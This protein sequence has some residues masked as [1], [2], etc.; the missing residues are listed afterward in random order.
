M[1]KAIFLSSVLMLC[2]AF[3]LAQDT[4]SSSSSQAGSNSTAS[5]GSATAPDQDATS[6]GNTIQGCLSGTSGNY[7]L[8]DATGVMYQLTGD[9]AQLSAN[10]NKE[11]EVT[12]T[13]GAKAS[14]PSTNSP[15]AN[16]PGSANAGEASASGNAAGT[17]ANGSP[18]ANAAKTLEVTSIKKVA[19]SCSSG[20]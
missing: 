19:D 20:K 11:V 10:L 15:E 2:A 14:T 18:N 6:S 3:A 4:P 9:E 16:A 17:S 8:T 7:M 5:Q 1:R 12:G 13:A